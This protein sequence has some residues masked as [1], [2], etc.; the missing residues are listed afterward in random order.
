MNNNVKVIIYDDSTMH[1][2]GGYLVNIEQSNEYATPPTRVINGNEFL[3]ITLQNFTVTG[4]LDKQF[5][6]LDPTTMKRILQYNTELELQ[7]LENKRQKAQKELNRLETSIKSLKK[8]FEEAQNFVA[9]FMSSSY[10][11]VEDYISAKYDTDVDYY[12]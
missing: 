10:S 12:E 4:Y 1:C 11:E 3:P 9:D 7:E 6:E 8:K 2:Y 5:I